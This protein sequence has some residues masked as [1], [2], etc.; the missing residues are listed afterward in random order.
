MSLTQAEAVAQAR[1][2]LAKRLGVTAG[3]I[4]EAV[5]AADFPNGALGAPL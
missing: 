4:T 1:A 2:D 5:E 3:D